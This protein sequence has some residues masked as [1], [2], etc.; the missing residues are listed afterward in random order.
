VLRRGRFNRTEARIAFFFAVLLFLAGFAGVGL[1]I[2]N[3]DWRV[4]LA[5]TGGVIL[6]VIYLVA[7]VRGRPL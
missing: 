1:G 3:H 7:A 6:G 2:R 5:G 4:A